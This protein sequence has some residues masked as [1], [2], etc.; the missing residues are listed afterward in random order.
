V[1][2]LEEARAL[3]Y[4]KTWL[5]NNPTYS[6]LSEVK[7]HSKEIKEYQ[8]FYSTGAANADPKAIDMNLSETVMRMFKAAAKA[9]PKDPELHTVSLSDYAVSKA[10]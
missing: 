1:L 6:S 4:L 5:E 10:A 2:D 9:N 7:A 8:Q 3:N